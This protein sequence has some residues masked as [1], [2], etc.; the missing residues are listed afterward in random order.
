[1]TEYADTIDDGLGLA[2]AWTN[3]WDGGESIPDESLVLADSQAIAW[4][5]S[6]SEDITFGE[7]QALM[8]GKTLNDLMF[9]Y[10]TIENGWG[11]TN[12][13]ASLV[14]NSSRSSYTTCLQGRNLRQASRVAE[15]LVNLYS[16]VVD[17]S[18]LRLSVDGL[19][20]HSAV[21]YLGVFSNFRDWTGD[22]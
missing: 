11:V 15:V 3:N 10:D 16:F 12:N 18:L 17:L 5:K 7:L 22:S 21:F 19:I 14:Y 8:F 6:I 4:P 20:C 2:D 1:M 9:L 13:E